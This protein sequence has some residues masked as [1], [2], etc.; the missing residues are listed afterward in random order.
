[1]KVKLKKFDGVYADEREGYKSLTYGLLNCTRDSSTLFGRL[2]FTARLDM[3]NHEVGIEKMLFIPCMP[4]HTGAHQASTE[5]NGLGYWFTTDTP[6]MCFSEEDVRTNLSFIIEFAMKMVRDVDPPHRVAMYIAGVSNATT[7]DKD[8]VNKQFFT[9]DTA[10]CRYWTLK[11]LP[12][13]LMKLVEPKKKPEADTSKPCCTESSC[14]GTPD[15]VDDAQNDYPKS[16]TCS[17]NTDNPPG[18]MQ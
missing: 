13:K 11:L 8:A 9:Y 3:D 7:V 16:A 2:F 5:Y 10:F 4:A 12:K 6:K 18:I 1:M 14:E 15:Q 17:D